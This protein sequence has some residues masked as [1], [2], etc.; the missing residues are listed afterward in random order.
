M[1]VQNYY[2][3]VLV[4][5][6]IV[7]LTG[8]ALYFIGLNPKASFGWGVLLSFITIMCLHLY[9]VENGT[10]IP[11]AGDL[12][13]TVYLS[14]SL[15]I[16]IILTFIY[17]CL[18]CNKSNRKLLKGLNLFLSE[19]ERFPNS[20][21]DTDYSD[22]EGYTSVEETTDVR[23]RKKQN[24]DNESTLYSYNTFNTSDKTVRSEPIDIDCKTPVEDGVYINFSGVIITQ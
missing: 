11:K 15:L 24:I 10:V 1:D 23:T 6:S 3:L 9:N 16:L 18:D 4:P 13:V 20:N 8:Y 21:D 7:I 19:D 14:I 17:C 2:I 12:Y 5:I 22:I